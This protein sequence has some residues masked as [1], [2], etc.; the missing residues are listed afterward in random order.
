MDQVEQAHS[1][2]DPPFNP[3]P[4]NMSAHPPHGSN[5]GDFKF[6]I[7]YC[8]IIAKKI[9]VYFIQQLI[10]DRCKNFLNQSLLEIST[11]L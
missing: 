5:A 11:V 3:L 10:L 7:N 4:Q 1:T 2:E 9:W 6:V 8:K